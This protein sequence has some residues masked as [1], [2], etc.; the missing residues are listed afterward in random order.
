LRLL[1]AV[2][3]SAG[4]ELG[5]AAFRGREGRALDDFAIWCALAEQHGDDWHLWPETLR[6]PSSPAVADFAEKHSA[7][8]DFHRWLQWQLDE[9]LTAAQSAALGAG[10]ALGIMTDLA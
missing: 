5:Y 9:Q 7:A 6:H 4:R 10:M 2:P 1:Y 3:R 8:V